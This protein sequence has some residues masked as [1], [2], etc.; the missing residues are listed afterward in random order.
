MKRS[1]FFALFVWVFAAGATAQST[2]DRENLSKGITA[3]QNKQYD[4]AIKILHP[5]ANKKST[6]AEYLMGEMYRLGQGVEKSTNIGWQWHKKMVRDLIRLK[7]Y[8]GAEQIIIF[9]VNAGNAE[10]VIEKAKLYI[11]AGDDQHRTDA[12]K[13][14]LD[15]AKKGNVYAQ[16]EMANIA[17]R[18]S[19][20]RIER[21]LRKAEWLEKAANNGYAPAQ[22]AYGR[23]FSN[24]LGR[25]KDLKAQFAWYQKAAK[26]GYAPAQMHF[27]LLYLRGDQSAYGITKSRKD[28]VTTAMQWLEKAAAQE[29]INATYHLA[30]LYQDGQFILPPQPEKALALFEKVYAHSRSEDPYHFKAFREIDKMKKEMA[31]KDKE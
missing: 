31:E 11:R 4:E 2:V 1:L 15:E 18:Q 25:A 14:I 20:T 12:R 30:D 19:G 16:Y 7:N 26:Q 8:Q 17:Y 24:N 9:W 21:W 27:G 23:G 22:D 3:Y 5:L 29:D 28:A 13:L 10:A 6:D